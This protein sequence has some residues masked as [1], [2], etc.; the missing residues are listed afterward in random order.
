MCADR[1]SSLENQGAKS[2]ARAFH[3]LHCVPKILVV[4]GEQFRQSLR[5]S[6]LRA[7]GLQV[8]VARSLDD[9]RRFLQ[10]H[11]YDWVFVDVHSQRPGEVVDFCER[12]RHTTPRQRI[13]FFVG[14]PTYV[15]AEWPSED[16]TEG[17]QEDR[18][19]TE[20]RAAA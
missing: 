1:T 5:A 16:V 19:A 6:V 9:S 7:H 13:A 10:R 14:A 8:D 11:T 20:L 17:K 12:L 4:G 15:S 2:T 3:G 18:R